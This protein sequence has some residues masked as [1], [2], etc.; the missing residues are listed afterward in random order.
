MV[1][2]LQQVSKVI[3]YDI[4]VAYLANLVNLDLKVGSIYTFIFSHYWFSNIILFYIM[5]PS[6][7]RLSVYASKN[8]EPRVYFKDLLSI[9]CLNALSIFLT[10]EFL[11]VLHFLEMF[12]T[13][14]YRKRREACNLGERC[15]RWVFVI[16]HVYAYI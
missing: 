8:L 12:Y 13:C 14:I 1:F 3:S 2:T 11:Q 16:M 5:R 4:E 9:C 6:I 7:I 10:W 15:G